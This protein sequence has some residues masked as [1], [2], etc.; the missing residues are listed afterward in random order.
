[1]DQE[2]S[3]VKT[4]AYR[5]G[6]KHY[7]AMSNWLTGGRTKALLNKAYPLALKYR[8]TLT[9]LTDCYKHARFSISRTKRMEAAHEYQTLVQHDIDIL[10][11]YDPAP[12]APSAEGI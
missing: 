2:C 6:D 1:M 8:Q 5:A 9:W 10:D 7:R 11:R 12:V 3:D 4:D